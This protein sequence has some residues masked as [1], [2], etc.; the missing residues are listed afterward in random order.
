M[1]KKLLV[2]I[3][4]IMSMIVAACGTSIPNPETEYPWCYTFDFINGSDELT[5]VEGQ[6]TVEGLQ[7]VNGLL[8]VSYQ[9]GQLVEPLYIRSELDVD[10]PG[11]PQ[12]VLASVSIFGIVDNFQQ[13]VPVDTTNTIDWIPDYAGVAGS[14]A[15][16]NITTQSDTLVTIPYMTV[17]GGGVNPFPS[18]SCGD[19]TPTATATY[20]I[21]PTFTPSPTASPTSTSTPTATNTP[22]VTNTPTSSWCYLVEGSELGSLFSV[23]PS[24]YG[25]WDA[26]NLRW[27][28]FSYSTYGMS[29]W[30]EDVTHS[31]FHITGI[32]VN[33][34]YDTTSTSTSDK[35]WVKDGTTILSESD[36]TVF[37]SGWTYYTLD[38]N[39]VDSV[40]VQLNVVRAA[41]GDATYGYIHAIKIVGDGVNPYSR[42]DCPTETPTLTSTE[43][44]ATSTPIA[45]T[46]SIATTTPIA[47]TPSIATTTPIATSTLYQTPTAIPT[48][49]LDTGETEFDGG[50]WGDT[51]SNSSAEPVDEN[52][53]SWTSW[54][55]GGVRRTLDCAIMPPIN[56]I[57]NIANSTMQAVRDIY[58]LIVAGINW[59]F[60]DL[61]PF[62]MG[63]ISNLWNM[64]I[65]FLGALINGAWNLATWLVDFVTSLAEAIVNFVKTII[66]FI[67]VAFRVAG[68]FMNL[69]N[70]SPPQKPP[71]LPD[72]VGNPTYYNICAVYYILEYT[73][74]AG[75]GYFIIPALVVYVSLLVAFFFLETVVERLQKVWEVLRG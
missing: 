13:S 57:L 61:F 43:G 44:G 27:E 52:N 35:F 29:V 56:S 24:Q 45:T 9:H 32:S 14:N 68:R 62:T 4:I 8:S 25:S 21:L 48:A 1:N 66:D 47:T 22:T 67:L 2:V 60:S 3:S 17:Y 30:I 38:R 20:N 42:N 40:A 58:N 75:I 65:Y 6:K 54:L 53:S 10:I 36:V 5:F 34:S 59:L 15:S 64:L 19:S 11:S 69:W 70:N 49:T 7:T 31:G 39:I 74:F 50:G 72:C 46:P 28:A 71:G 55:L 41:I 37:Y 23:R 51:C 16:L 63:W 73:V 26:V 12:T 18:N 33:Y